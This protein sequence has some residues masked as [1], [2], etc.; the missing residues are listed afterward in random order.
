MPGFDENGNTIEDTNLEDV[1]A[2][3]EPA[4]LDETVGDEVDDGAAEPGANDK[5]YKIGDKVFKTLEEAH[6]YATSQLSE[7]EVSQQVADAYRQGIHDAAL[8]NQSVT[9][10]QAA[11]EPEDDFN[12]EEYYANPKEFLKNFKTQ[13]Q[14]EVLGTIEKTAAQRAQEAQVW[15]EF[16][17]RHP[18]FADTEFRD[19]IEK[20][21][22][23]Y[24]TE[25]R[26]IISTKGKDA[27]YDFCALKL[28]QKVE[29]YTQAMKPKRQLPNTSQGASPT[30][31]GGT[32][33]NVTP[34][35]GQEKP[36]SFSDQI[37]M[38]KRKQR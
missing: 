8:Q 18:A 29:R 27:A 9:P 21:A 15:S 14:Q 7:L 19:D 12:E 32:P 33:K 23:Q 1:N 2:L 3:T 36:L 11:P 4:D 25:L 5:S 13:V 16:G 24:Q 26:A 35:K 10:G 17:E 6:A 20:I 38:L 37:K 28:R 30:N 22:N 34:K 31:S